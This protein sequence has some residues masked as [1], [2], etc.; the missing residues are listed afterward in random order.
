MFQTPKKP[1][2]PTAKKQLKTIKPAKK[3]K[4]VYLSSNLIIPTANLNAAN[5]QIEEYN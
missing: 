1:K 5:I 4:F 3:S 2:V